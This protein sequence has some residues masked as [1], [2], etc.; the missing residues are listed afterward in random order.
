MVALPLFFGCLLSGSPCAAPASRGP[1]GVFWAPAFAA[2]RSLARCRPLGECNR[3]VFDP[4]PLRPWARASQGLEVEKPWGGIAL[5]FFRAVARR[6]IVALFSTPA[7]Y[8]ATSRGF[9]A[10]P[11]RTDDRSPG[12]Q[13]LRSWCRWLLRYILGLPSPLPPVS[14]R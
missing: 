1:L 3:V 12:E 4:S 6:A 5:R 2:I 9:A 14:Q 10:R 7:P 11:R 8:A 13:S